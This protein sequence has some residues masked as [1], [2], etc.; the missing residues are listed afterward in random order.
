MTR[1]TRSG[2]FIIALCL[3]GILLIVRSLATVHHAQSAARAI[4][5]G[6]AQARIVRA[7]DAQDDALWKD[8]SAAGEDWASKHPGAQPDDCPAY[9]VDFRKA[10]AATLAPSQP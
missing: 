6:E 9:T 2:L 1:Q 10:C 4:A 8:E 5:A 3:V 7:E